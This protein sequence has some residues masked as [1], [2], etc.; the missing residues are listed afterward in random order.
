[1]L[2][3]VE[4]GFDSERVLTMEISLPQPAYRGDPSAAFFDRLLL[5]IQALPGVEAAGVTSG[6]PLSG[7]EFLLP[8]V[9]EGQPRP[10]P[11]HDVISDYRIVTPGYFKALRI[12][13]VAGETL[14]EQPVTGAGNVIVINETMARTC[15]PGQPAIGRQVR[16]ATFKP[17]YRVIG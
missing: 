1:K 13:L 3:A 14:P 17:I 6:L 2:T 9:P 7:R 5:R 11:G 16:L 8:G 4:T 10:E 12:P 15:W